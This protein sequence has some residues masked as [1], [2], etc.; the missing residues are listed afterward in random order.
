MTDLKTVT[1]R[2]YEL[3]QSAVSDEAIATDY[4]TEIKAELGRVPSVRNDETGREL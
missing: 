4:L 1:A 3:I 2:L